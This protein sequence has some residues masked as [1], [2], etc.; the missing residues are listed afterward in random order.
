M[1]RRTVMPNL[2]WKA[3]NGKDVPRYRHTWTEGGKRRERTI[4]LAWKDDPEEL[5]RLYWDCRRGDH[6]KQKAP[7][8]QYSWQAL[9]IGWRKDAVVQRRLSN[10]TKVSYHRTMDALLLK[11]ADKDIRHTTRKHIR[12]ILATLAQTPRKADHMVQIIRL[13]WNFAR[14]ELEW[15]IGDNPAA[16]VALFGKTREFEPWPDW[17][18]KE[19]TTAPPDVQAVVELILG[20]GQRPNAALMMRHDDFNG[21]EMWVRD[22]KA[23]ERFMVA[24]PD[25]L[26]LFVASRAKKGAFIFAKNLTEPKG[27]SIIEKHFRKWRKTL[28]ERANPFS[29]HGLRKLAIIQLALAGC[30]DA[31]IQAV[32]NQSAATVADYRKKAN[33]YPLSKAAQDKRD[34]NKNGT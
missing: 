1:T 7:A 21:K 28:G 4:T 22:E 3:V 6:P 20:T 19:V 13:L 12:D 5:D 29:M 8:P 15:E 23:N 31:E 9:V 14:K 32:T 27:Y 25:R 26:R 34:Q 33:R 17:M 30:S 11:N 16:D 18:V 10:S 2:E 24:C